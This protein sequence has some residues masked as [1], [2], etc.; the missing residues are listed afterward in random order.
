MS[1]SVKVE[2]KPVEK[3]VEIDE[4]LYDEILQRAEEYKEAKEYFVNVNL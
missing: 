3:P 2:E 4:K 1:K